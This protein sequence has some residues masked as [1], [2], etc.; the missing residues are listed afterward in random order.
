MSKL[1]PVDGVGIAASLMGGVLIY[2]G[3][4]GYSVLMVL[5]N[6]VTG[7]PITTDVNVTNPLKTPGSVLDTPT[8]PYSPPTGGAQSIGQVLASNMGW[9]GTEWTALQTLWNGESGWNPHAKNPSSG[10][11]GIPQALPYTKMPKAAWPESAGG[12][13]D[14]SAQIQWGLDYIKGRYGSP[15]MALAFWQRQS[16]H[17]Y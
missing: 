7:K 3:I 13:S 5:Q 2:G 9:E 14:A 17:W 15:S 12:S 11:Y 6:L 8:E 10:A 4:K 16:P 1:N